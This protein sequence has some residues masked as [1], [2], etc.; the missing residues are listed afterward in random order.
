MA[1]APGDALYAGSGGHAEVQIGE[2]AFVR[3]GDETE[4]TVTNQE[5]DFVH[6]NVASGRAVLDVRALERGQTIEIDTPNAAVTVEDPG[7]YR[8]EVGQETT[9]LTTRRAGRARV[10]ANGGQAM[11]VGSNDRLVIEG[12]DEPRLAESSAPALDDWDRWNYDRTD[13]LLVAA[14]TRYLPRDV[15]G[16]EALDT[17]GTWRVEPTY[18]PVWAPSYVPPGWAPYSTGQWTWD[19]YYG[20]TWVDTAP[21]GWAPFHYGRWVYLR[22]GWGWTPGPVLYRPVYSPALVAFFGGP[23]FSVGIGAPYVS[24]VALGW[25]EPIIPWWGPVGFVGVP[26]WHGWGG[27]HVVNNVYVNN[28]TS[29]HVHQPGAFVNTRVHGAI[30]TMPRSG[31]GRQPVEWLRR[32][33][34]NPGAMRPLGGDL[35][36]PAAL[37][38]RRA[39][40]DLP[41]GGAS[42]SRSGFDAPRP[43]SLGDRRRTPPQIG[44]QAG[45]QQ[46]RQPLTNVQQPPRVATRLGPR[47]GPG[48]APEGNKANSAFN[49]VPRLQPPPPRSLAGGSYGSGEQRLE[50]PPPRQ[51]WRTGGSTTA[52]RPAPAPPPARE[53]AREPSSRWVSAPQPPRAAAQPPAAESRPPAPAAPTGAPAAR[54]ARGGGGEMSRAR[55]GGTAPS[56]NPAPPAAAPAAPLPAPHVSGG[57]AAASRGHAVHAR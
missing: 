22:S 10:R 44:L 3:L 57:S 1:L 6:L 13:R 18:G 39:A 28:T 37:T 50:A 31:F 26:C 23:G 27:P 53:A 33:A 55:G 30:N 46:Q 24:W 43:T 25:G 4:F 40:P 9:T 41:Q 29:V 21:W 32:P 20:W 51:D 48:V 45:G 35:P 47:V 12:T 49:T 56:A 19:S 54:V 11:D 36:R 7:Y 15:Y 14:S 42:T 17:Y 8:V 16:A 2:R 38:T 34:P 5:P 52:P